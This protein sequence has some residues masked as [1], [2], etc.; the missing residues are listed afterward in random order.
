MSPM[1]QDSDSSSSSVKELNRMTLPSL[2]VWPI[3]ATVGL[4]MFAFMGLVVFIALPAH[5]I[6]HARPTLE[7]MSSMTYIYLGHTGMLLA[8]LFWIALLSHG[9]FHEFGL[10]LPPN[11]RYIRIALIFG[12]LFGIVMKAVDYSENFASHV[13]PEAV[14][15]SPTQV[16]GHLAFEGFYAGTVEEILFR[17]LLMTFLVQRM[18]G[19]ARFGKFDL[20]VGGVIVAVLFAIVHMTSFWTD[21]FR[22]AAAQ[23]AYAFLWGIAYAYWRE[24]SGSL[25]P[26]IVGHNVGNFVADVLTYLVPWLWS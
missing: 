5:L 10:K 13:P 21:T 17:G 6:F 20:H 25:L 18:S 16:A 9:R 8:A 3:I 26:S 4:I 2:K 14:S 22:L 23:Q 24:K 12:I 11:A 19:R 7:T 15:S 1:T